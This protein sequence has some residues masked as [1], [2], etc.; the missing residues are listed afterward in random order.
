MTGPHFLLTLAAAGALLAQASPAPHVTRSDVVIVGAG[1][2]GLAAAIEAEKAGATVTV[3]DMWSVFGGHAVMSV[4]RFHNTRGRGLGLVAPL[5]LECLKSRRIS[6]QWN[7]K[8]VRLLT[9]RQRVVG[10]EG[11]DLRTGVYREFR[12]RS[13]ILATGGF[14]SNLQMVREHWPRALP[15]PPRI[16]VGSGLNSVGAGHAMARSAGAALSRMDHQ[17]N[18]P[19]GLPDPRFPGSARGVLVRIGDAIWVNADAQRFVNEMGGSA[20]GSKVTLPVVLREP[21][22][23]FWAI[24]DDEARRLVTISGTDWGDF[25]LIQRLVFDNLDVVRAGPSLRRHLPS[26]VRRSVR[27]R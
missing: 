16:L 7:T 12:A 17:W 9:D 11:Q 26:R 22:A 3:P 15:T 24:L 21:G 13:T 1:I 19:V 14:Q 5:Y 27:P 4:P 25:A 2:S 23:T 20:L 18:Y 10:V 8:A 6:F